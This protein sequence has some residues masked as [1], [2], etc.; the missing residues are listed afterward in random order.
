MLKWVRLPVKLSCMEKDLLQLTL[1][2]PLD[3]A[4]IEVLSETLEQL[5]S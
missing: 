1:E 3:L 5:T 2:A 4:M